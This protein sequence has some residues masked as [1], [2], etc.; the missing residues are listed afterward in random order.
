[1]IKIL[2]INPQ[3]PFNASPQDSWIR[4]GLAHLSSVLKQD[5][6]NDVHLIDF[7][8]ISGWDDFC[9]RVS[10]IYP[11]V[12]F[13]TAFTSEVENTIRAARVIKEIKPDTVIV[14]GGIHASI[15]PEDFQK[16]GCFDFIMRGEGEITVPKI[17]AGF[18]ELI[19]QITT[20][21][22]AR[23]PSVL[24]GETPDLDKIP[25]ADRELWF[26]YRERTMH[27]PIWLR[28]KPWVDILM[29]RG[30]PYRCKFCSGPGEQNHYT[31]VDSEGNR[32]PYIRGRSVQNVIDELLVLDQKYHYKSIQFLDDQFIMNPAWAWDFMKALKE[33]GLDSKQWWAGSRADVILRNKDLVLEMQRCGLDIMSVGFESFS[34]ELLRFWGKGTTVAQ[35][36]EAAQ[37]LNDHGI[38]IF[39]NTIM[40]APRPDTKWHIEDDWRNIEALK[41]IKPSFASWSIFTAVPGSELYQWCIDNN[42][43]VAKNTGI[44]AA[45]ENKIKGISY[46]KIR[47]MMDEIDSCRRPWYHTMNDRLRALIEGD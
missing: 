20:T 32:K 3:M 24:W 31:K 17:A 25:F 6:T 38:R 37:F 28:E 44:R 26:D 21:P 7:R 29:V 45:D 18:M 40:G 36:F 22:G 14:V 1:M 47:V 15:A 33:Y 8:L 42:L 43:T 35:N 41:L 4:L 39:S 2:L 11:D 10:K 5:R 30:C 23:F 46:R 9:G 16:A 27:P 34:D 19:S 12:V 13:I